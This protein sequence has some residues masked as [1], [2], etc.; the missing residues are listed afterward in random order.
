MDYTIELNNA[1]QDSLSTREKFH[2]GAPVVEV[3]SSFVKGEPITTNVKDAKVADKAMKYIKGL[4]TRA[5]AGDALAVSEL[6]ALRV[7]E[8]EPT[9]LQEI[10]LLGIFGSYQAMGW[11]ETIYVKTHKHIGVDPQIQAEGNDVTFPAIKAE[12]Y[13]IAPITVSGGYA[14]NYRQMELGDATLEN[15]GMEEVRKAI[16]NKATLYV[17]NKIITSI[18]NANGVKYYDEEAGLSKAGVDGVL[19]AI[20]RFGRPNVL[21]DYAL[22]SQFVNFAGWN[23]TVTGIKG[24]SDDMI[25]ELQ[26]EGFLGR[27]NGSIISEIQNPYNLNKI[28]T[29]GSGN[30]NFAPLLPTGFGFVVPQGQST[31]AVQTFTQGG[32]TS[33]SGNDVT[34]GEILTRFDLAVAAD[35]VKGREYE[36]GVLEDTNL[37][38][39][40]D[41]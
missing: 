34:T 2:K 32:L 21:G 20:R 10:K 38:H 11:N 19:N 14:V 41:I 30:K 17:M 27:Y 1:R 29:D 15:E 9:L 4:A 33:F 13:Q 37:V 3:F 31:S 24:V 5:Q 22:V 26:A 6:N 40:F 8:I 12:K 25:N 39:T 35:V 36:I 23:S 18:E 28:V 7:I 16:R